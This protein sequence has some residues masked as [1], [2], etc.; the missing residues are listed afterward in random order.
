VPELEIL[1]LPFAENPYPM[2]IFD[3]ETLA[4]LEVNYAAT[5]A[6]G[7]SRAEFLAMTLLDIRPAE[8]IPEP[9]RETKHPQQS[10]AETWRHMS[11]D[12]VV[13]SVVITSWELIFNGHSAELVLA[14]REGL[15]LP[16]PLPVADSEQMHDRN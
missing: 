8:D 3:R 16:Q 11:K 14:R 5:R 13:F 2:W 6:Y 9:L 4:F 12:G 7:F 10:T 1:G 15:V